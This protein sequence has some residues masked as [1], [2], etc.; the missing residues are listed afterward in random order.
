MEEMS[1]QNGLE[2]LSAVSP[3]LEKIAGDASVVNPGRVRA[4]RLLAAG[5]KESP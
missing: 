2:G 1:K 5:R 4:Q 3:I